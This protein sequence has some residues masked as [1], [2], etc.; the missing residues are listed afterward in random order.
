MAA[1]SQDRTERATPKRLRDA[2]KRGEVPRSRELGAAAVVGA[3]SLAM[4]SAGA[5]VGAG[6]AAQMRELL[7]FD[8][9]AL[10]DPQSLPVRLGRAFMA[11]MSLCAPVFGACVLA[12][13]AAPALLGGFN[14]SAQALRLDFSRLNPVSGL[15]RM[16]SSHGLM[17]LLKGLIKLAWIGG[18]GSL[19]LWQHRAAL[20]ALS[21]EPADSGIADGTAL[22]FGAGAW[23]ALSLAAVAA[24]DAPYQLWSYAKRL[25]MSRQEVRDEMKQSEGR[26]E[27]KA[28]VRRLQFEMTKRRM[29]EKIPTADVVVTNPTHYAVALKYSSEEMRA[30]RVVAKGA[31]EIAAVIR[32]LAREHRIPLISAPP[33]AR[34]LYREVNLE[35]E[36]PAG[37]YAAVARVLTYVYQLRGWRGGTPPPVLAPI[38]EVPGGEPDPE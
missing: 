33:L 24:I 13:L 26:P 12:A 15:G 11:A 7:S 19:Y 27:V 4:V 18:V 6:A 8:A 31:G 35:Q 28:K 5:R 14:F 32:E 29:M 3:A 17:E 21:A 2:R 34:A 36:I 38:G 10:A 22:V 9:S 30:P 37:L 20:V 25:R 23:L 16:F 1:S